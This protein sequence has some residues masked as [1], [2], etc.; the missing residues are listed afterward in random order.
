MLGFS[1][2]E[3]K[4]SSHRGVSSKR[5]PARPTT[6]AVVTTNESPSVPAAH[7]RPS[8]DE[9]RAVGLWALALS[10]VLDAAAVLFWLRIVVGPSPGR[11]PKLFG[12]IYVAVAVALL[13]PT[14]RRGRVVPRPSEIVLTVAGRVALA[15]LLTAMLTLTQQDP[16]IK[17]LNIRVY[18]FLVG[19]T[20]ITVLLARLV[21]F[22]LT[23]MARRRG[24]DLEDTLIVGAGPV[25][26]QVAEALDENHEFGLTPYGF[27]DRFEDELPYPTVGRPEDLFDVLADTG[28]RH[29]V[30]AFGS[31]SEIEI[32][33]YVRQVAHLPVTFYA[34]PRFFELGASHGGVGHE[35]DGFSLVPLR[36]PGSHCGMW[37]VKRA[38]DLLVAS[39]MLVVTA[40]VMLACAIAV[41]L[42]SPGPVLFR[43]VRV[44]TDGMPFEILKFRS[45][46]VNDDSETQWTVDADARVTSVGRFLR[47]SHLDEL[48]QMINVL[49]GEMSIV[50]PRPERPHFV[51]QFGTEIDGYHHR[52]RVPAGITGWA[53]VNGFWGDSSIESRVRLDNRYIENWSLWR[54]L[55]ISMRTIPTF[56]GKRR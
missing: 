42:S 9:R 3:Q 52:H 28:I 26:V 30:L 17:T 41:K 7:A 6:L 34:V 21:V 24:Y 31:A 10:V 27:L 19:T 33:S 1:A 4:T 49:K 23:Q 16:L 48:P 51:E 14:H 15:P 53:Q 46:T 29:V 36:R 44:S 32:V 25:G 39:V 43:Q 8:Q 50:G 13:I 45:M 40:P 55:V 47:K 35:V 18:A 12:A 11:T 5:A 38:F 20:A 37:P 2:I 54:D 22:K 56:L